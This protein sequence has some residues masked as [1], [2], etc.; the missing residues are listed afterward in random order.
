MT[1]CALGRIRGHLQ[2]RG[3]MFAVEQAG[4][5]CQLSPMGGVSVLLTFELRYIGV[6]YFN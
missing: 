3:I 1:R 4:I 5:K 6:L 2:V